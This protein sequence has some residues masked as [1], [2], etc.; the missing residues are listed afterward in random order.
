MEST[1]EAGD[2]VICILLA[3]ALR[4]TLQSATIAKNMADYDR[5]HIIDSCSAA[6]LIRIMAEHAC[7]LRDLGHS[8]EEIVDAIEKL[9]SRVKVVAALDTLEYLYKGGRLSR[10]AAAIGEFANLK[11]VIT[12][13]P[14][15][16]IGI[17]GKCIGK[18]K[19]INSILKQLNAEKLDNS[20][21]FYTLYTYGTD[22]CQLLESKLEASD[23]HPTERVQIGPTIGS[24]VGP[25]AFGVIYVVEE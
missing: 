10:T 1:K 21:P 18:N 16:T 22:N 8:A 24:H 7:M 14:E 15:G 25:E 13:T 12:L 6:Y 9:K 20:F 5:I 11:P 23:L 2:D 17:V 4:G 19:A 3:S